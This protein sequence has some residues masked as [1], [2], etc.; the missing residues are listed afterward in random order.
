MIKHPQAQKI[1]KTQTST[2][3]E[4]IEVARVEVRHGQHPSHSHDFGF[5]LGAFTE[6]AFDLW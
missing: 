3:T 4:S 2:R 5:S 1:I 6:V